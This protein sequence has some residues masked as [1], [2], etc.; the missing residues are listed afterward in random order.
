VDYDAAV[1]LAEALYRL[2][3]AARNYRHP[4]G[5]LA[6]RALGR[7]TVTVTDRATSLRFRCLKDADRM[8][9]EI[10]HSRVYDVP[11]APVRAGDVVVDVG[12][13]HGFAAC[14]FA[15]RG[16][17]VLAFEPSPRVF[18]LLTANIAANGL[19]DRITA[20]PEAVAGEEGTATLLVSPTLGGGMT[21]LHPGFV[22]RHQLPVEQRVPVRTRSLSGVLGE[23]GIGRVRLL[24]LDCEGSELDI[25]R[26]LDRETL[27]RIDSL[28][29]EYHSDVYPLS[30]LV[31]LVLDWGDFHLSKVVTPDVENANLHAVH[32]RALE[33]WAAPAG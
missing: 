4:L 3:K 19:G 9:G 31:E 5:L 29:I 22:E 1:I 17:R 23:L 20:F 26:S 30:S 32:R 13:N 27:D 8:L 10:V 7:P 2:G 12:A 14:W 25:L 6:Q 11:T 15:S 18:P 16:A 21:T 24:K 33:E 28:A